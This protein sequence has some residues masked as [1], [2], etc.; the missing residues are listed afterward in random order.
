MAK[1]DRKTS[2]RYFPKDLSLKRLCSPTLWP[3]GCWWDLSISDTLE[4]SHKDPVHCGCQWPS[5]H[6]SWDQKVKLPSLIRQQKKK[7]LL[8]HMGS[9][10]SYL[11]GKAVTSGYDPL[12]QHLPVSLTWLRAEQH[13][14]KRNFLSPLV[15]KKK[16]INKIIS[17]LFL[18]TR[19]PTD[20]SK[21]G[22]N[23]LALW[24][25]SFWK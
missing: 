3:P 21:P 5:D 11:G 22:R 14:G 9:S 16:K 20:Q 8:L 18:T 7:T 24:E 2:N 17:N 15:N 23:A 10:P 12:F 19:C 6:C 4:L 25:N 13:S 1:D